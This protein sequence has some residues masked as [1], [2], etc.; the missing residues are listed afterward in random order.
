MPQNQDY[1][2][3]SSGTNSQ[4]NHYCARDY[5][6]GAANS[7]SYHIPTAMDHTTTPIPM[8]AH[9]TMMERETQAILLREER[10][11]GL[12]RRRVR[13]LAFVTTRTA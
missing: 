6:S 10:N 3:K 13:W 7:N 12:L 8:V 11:E 9:T 1:T 4:G 5:G 2:Y